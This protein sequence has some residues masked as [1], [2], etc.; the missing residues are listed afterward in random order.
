M[1]G[2]QVGTVL[3]QDESLSDAHPVGTS[4][5]VGLALQREA[6]SNQHADDK[7]DE[8]QAD[9][10]RAQTSGNIY[11][12]VPDSFL[13]YF[14]TVTFSVTTNASTIE[15]VRV[16]LAFAVQQSSTFI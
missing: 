12:P 2:L 16:R 10:A 6:P 4:T 15:A 14:A 1:A 7:V 3:W 9:L 8:T 11:A 5:K 13:D